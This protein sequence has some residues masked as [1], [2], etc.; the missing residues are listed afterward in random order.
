[1]KIA[2][3]IPT[4]NRASVLLETLSD[5]LQ[6]EPP[7][8][9]IVVV[10]QSDW[11]PEGAKEALLALAQKG[12]IRYFHQEEANLPKA[13]NR[14]LSETAYDIVIFID[15]DVQLSPGCIAAHLA[16][17]R[18][19]SVWAVCGRIT[20]LDIPVR[21]EADRTW[22]KALDYKLFDLGWT[23]SIN[24]FG[25]VKGCNHSVRRERVL[26]LGGYDEAFIGVALREETDLAF[27]I[28]EAGGTIRF[29]PTAHLHH[30]RAPASGCRVSAWGDWSAGCAVLRFALKHRKPLGRYFWSE[31]WH[32][33][34][35]GVL[36]RSS[37]SRPARIII[38]TIMFGCFVISELCESG[39]RRRMENL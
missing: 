23:I 27:R 25:N 35:L 28:V 18:D 21:P 7:A 38:R 1:M 16:N 15:D 31:L 22:P 29:D 5:V 9:E 30:L 12:A 19:D 4:F 3:G 17:Y 6:Q 39:F 24:D 11:Y 20:E 14:I 37:A 8:D 26:T 32:A 13:R 2:V 33:Y 10:D 36:N 34:R